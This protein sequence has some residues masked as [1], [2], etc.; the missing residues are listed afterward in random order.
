MDVSWNPSYDAQSIF[1]TYRFGQTKEC[2]VYRLVS[3]VKVVIET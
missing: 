1:R 2:F 3:K